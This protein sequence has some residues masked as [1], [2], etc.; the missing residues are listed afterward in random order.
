MNRIYVIFLFTFSLFFLSACSQKS[1]YLLLQTKK[2]LT[3]INTTA[4]SIEYK[5]L[6][7]DRLKVI[8]YKDPAEI[9]TVNA[10]KIG[11]NLNPEG[12]LV[13]A[14]GF[15]KLPLL[16]K[17]KV[18]GLTQT[19]ASDKIETLYK[20]I[21]TE[22]SVYVEIMNK[23]VIVLG[24]VNK[25]GVVKLDKEKMTLF[26]ALGFAGGL[27]DSAVRDKVIIV[28]YNTKK[29]MQMRSVDL[30]DFDKLSYETLMLRPNDIVYVK[31]D[32]WKEFRVKSDNYTSPF[33][34][35]TKIVSPFV[36]L[37]YLFDR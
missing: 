10:S 3:D 12:I 36:T 6:P 4:V 31:P 2:S 7:Q 17:I 27:K 5:I 24:E 28:S 11:E 1:N 26:E 32:G 23:R 21:L 25:P 9:S 15:I 30:T 8:L 20:K 29:S 37:K 34:T 14:A 35:F 19:Q 16:G 13:N 33:I 22:P 18:A